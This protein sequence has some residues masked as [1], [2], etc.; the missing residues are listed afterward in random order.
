MEWGIGWQT[1]GFD[2]REVTRPCTR[3]CADRQAEMCEDP[4]DYGRI[5]DGGDDFHGAAALGTVFHV[6]I[7]DALEQPGPADARRPEGWAVLR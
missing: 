4:G 3:R 5:F 6:D 1:G 7:E 2:E